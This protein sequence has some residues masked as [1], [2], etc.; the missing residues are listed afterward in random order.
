[1]APPTKSTATTKDR[2]PAVHIQLDPG[3]HS[4]VSLVRSGHDIFFVSPLGEVLAALVQT[5]RPQ[6]NISVG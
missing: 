4:E 6:L 5:G 2:T 1:M 3:H